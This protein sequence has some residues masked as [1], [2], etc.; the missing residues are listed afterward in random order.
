M[1]F[2]RD[3]SNSEFDTESN[4]SSDEKLL[5]SSG[6]SRNDDSIPL[7]FDWAK[8]ICKRDSFTFTGNIGVKFIVINKKN[9]IEFFER[10]F[11]AN[12]YEYLA[13]ETNRF[14][15]KFFHKYIL[16]LP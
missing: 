16:N 4:E 3:L 13:I 10:F 2:Y 14:A 11:D 1:S 9:P 7:P 15:E 8:S 5:E 6:K 12:V